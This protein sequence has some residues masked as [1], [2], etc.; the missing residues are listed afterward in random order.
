M[1]EEPCEVTSL[2][3]GF[4]AERRGRLLRLGNH[5][6]ILN[7]GVNA[8]NTWREEH[9]GL[10]PNFQ[11]ADLRNTYLR[12]ANMTGEAN[13]TR[14]DLFQANL[15]G[16]NLRSAV[17]VNTDLRE[18]TLTQCLIYGISAWNVKL[19]STVYNEQ[20]RAQSLPQCG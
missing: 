16:A 3:H 17:V 14:A 9:P 5:L 8:W 19:E 20:P 1:L 11:E 2:T 4:E 6:D 13:L 12:E 7:Q 18:A 15:N 10:R